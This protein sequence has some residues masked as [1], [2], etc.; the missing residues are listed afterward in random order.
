MIQ[1]K[2]NTIGLKTN[3]TN[4]IFIPIAQSDSKKNTKNILD[5]KQSN[6]VNTIQWKHNSNKNL[7]SDPNKD[8][9]ANDLLKESENDLI[10]INH[11]HKQSDENKNNTNDFQNKNFDKQKNQKNKKFEID[12]NWNIELKYEE[13]DFASESAKEKL[14][15]LKDNLSFSSSALKEESDRK[16]E[17]TNFL[18]KTNNNNQNNENIPI[19]DLVASSSIKENNKFDKRKKNKE[20]GDFVLTGFEERNENANEEEENCSSVKNKNISKN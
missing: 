1:N 15:T 4:K 7:D 6:T 5:F 11:N 13:A 3:I 12:E 8:S 20:S 9:K 16:P 10:N 14:K 19:S 2:Q 18:S 17:K